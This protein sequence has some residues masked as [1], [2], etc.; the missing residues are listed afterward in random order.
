MRRLHG[1]LVKFVL[2]SGLV[3]CGFSPGPAGSGL[4]PTGSGTGVAAN[5]GGASNGGGGISGNG[6]GIGLT[7]GGGGDIVVTGSGGMQCGVSSVPVMPE[8]PDVL[9]V[10][11][12]SGS[13]NDNDA[14]QTCKGGCGTMS[15][16]SELSVAMT[17]VV[18]ATQ[19]TV[20]WGLKYFSD[21][22]ACDASNAPVVTIGTANAG[23]AIVASI[24]GTTAGGNTPTRD[25]ITYGAQ[26]LATLTD[27]NPKFLLLATDGLPNCPSGCASMQQPSGSCTMTDNPSEDMA[28]E[29]AIMMAAMQGF[30]TFVVGIGNVTS[31]VNT[32]NQMAINGGQAQT[33]GATS[34][35]A[36]TD[37][38]ALEAALMAI[39]GKVA[40]CTIPLTGVPANLTNVAVSVDDANGNPTK[41]PQDPNN[42][43]SYTDSTMKAIQLNG[44]YCDSI[45]SGTYS[46]VKFVYACDGQPICID[47]LANGTC[48][49]AS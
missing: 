9:I 2:I 8:P 26:Y 17:N 30:Q 36:A 31:A 28:A 6:T 22:G 3:G 5:G 24:Q 18:M 15:K 32:L 48:G 27:S 4:V 12:K 33:G 13:M 40:S 7:S 38:A 1:Q 29:G 16:W 47:K 46:N 11:D 20:N 14:D 49:D 37:E 23:N 42:G 35:Y 34:Y 45:K 44:S 10:Q 25:A 39:V 19:T 41:V 21:N 43:W